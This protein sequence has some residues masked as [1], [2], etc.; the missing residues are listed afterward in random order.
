MR[1]KVTTKIILICDGIYHSRSASVSAWTAKIMKFNLPFWL[2]CCQINFQVAHQEVIAIYFRDQ[3]CNWIG[4]IFHD[5]SKWSFL[6]LNWTFVSISIRFPKIRFQRLIELE[7]SGKEFFLH[8]SYGTLILK[9]PSTLDILISM[10]LELLIQNQNE[11]NIS[12]FVIHDIRFFALW[13]LFG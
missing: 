3:S 4:L 13:L 5:G 8:M 2:F 11:W 6:P 10:W 9:K 1:Q 7:I 12:L